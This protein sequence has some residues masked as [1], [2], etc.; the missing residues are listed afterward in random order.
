MPRQYV[1]L[2][3]EPARQAGGEVL[4]RC[5]ACGESSPMPALSAQ[6]MV[7]GWC[8]F[9][10][11][12]EAGPHLELLVD[13]GSFRPLEAAPAGPARLGWA[14][15]AGRPLAV[16]VSDPASSWDA[17]EIG[18]LAAL[19][20]EA[21]R[22]H[23]SLLWVVTAAQGVKAPLRWAGLQLA[24]DRL[25]EAGAESGHGAPAPWIA[26]VAGPAYGPAAALAA[27]ADLVLAEPGA[28]LAP[29]LPEALRQAGRLPIESTRPPRQLLRAGWADA[30]V[31]RHEQRTA[32]ADLLD[33]LG[34]AGEGAGTRP[35]S[36]AP[37]RLPA[38]FHGL[39]ASFRELAGDRQS[40]D[41]PALVGGLA[42]LG[43]DGMPLLVLATACAET[44][45]GVRRRHAG[46]ISAAGWRKATRLLRLA[47]RFGLPVV[48]LVDRPTLRTGRHDDPGEAAAALGRT[49]HTLL[50]LPVPTIAVR[51]AASEGLSTVVLSTSDYLLV[52][53]DL[54][55]QLQQARLPVSG[56]FEAHEL[57]VHL[58]RVLRELRQAYVEH[59]ALGRRALSQHRYVRWARLLPVP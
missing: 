9:H 29:V 30:V 32:L 11:P 5:P 33:L 41:D 25:G 1:T 13:E 19:A 36:A 50:A 45:A 21:G 3:T 2:T 56:T 46:A 4:L 22:R 58:A 57:E 48:L 39:F 18:A 7:C 20:E 42:R 38:P 49:L 6:A 59:G 28:V 51:V 37:E 27:Q 44:R 14:T 47:G 31:P 52:Q 16:A 10:F 43:P 53:Q 26:L 34:A 40:V 54:A 17:A 35:P 55:P 8:D 24:L 12:L 15:L 23:Q